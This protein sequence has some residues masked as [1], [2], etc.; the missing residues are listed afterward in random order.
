MTASML[1]S[2]EMA[3]LKMKAGSTPR[4]SSAIFAQL[5]VEKT[6][7]RVPVS[8]AV[9]MYLP[10]RLMSMARRDV[11]C[12]GMMLTLLDSSSTIWTLPGDRPGKATT[13]E[14]KQHRPSGLSAV[15]KVEC[16]VGGEDIL[17]RVMLLCNAATI[18]D[19]VSRVRNMAVFSSSVMAAFCLA[20]SQI[21]TLV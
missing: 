2:G 13:L 12:A 4:R 16:F 11:V 7:I 19:L 1:E 21:M 20:S 15:S 9:A 5:A 8:L 3:M 17:Y 14:P 18:Q 10:S 6:R